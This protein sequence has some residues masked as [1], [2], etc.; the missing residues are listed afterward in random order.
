LNREDP[1][2][3]AV[4]KKLWLHHVSSHPRNTKILGNAAE[5]FLLNDFEQSEELLKQARSAEPDNPKW[6]ERLGHPYSLRSSRRAPGQRALAASAFR[7]F[8]AAERLQLQ[9]DPHVGPDGDPEAIEA[10]KRKSRLMWIHKLP[11]LAKAAFD[12]GEFEQ[13][14]NYAIELLEKAASSEVP[15]FFR[16]DGN[17]VHHGNLIL[18][19][20]ALQSGY[21]EQAKQ[22]LVA[23]AETSGSPQ[24]NSFGPNM[25]LAKELLEQG[26]RDVV[27]EYFTRCGSFWKS[28]TDRLQEWTSQ[29]Q[30][31]V[32]PEFGPN[33]RY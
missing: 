28:G 17:A 14:R 30:R 26:E 23:S 33:L 32:I 2:P 15:E 25:S 16:N 13:A 9:A 29:V 10:A 3:Y 4:A 18:G 31:G 6:P 7:E 21:V 11:Q 27:L 12:A 20:V 1:Q 5:F 22:H 19:R 8:Q 24:L